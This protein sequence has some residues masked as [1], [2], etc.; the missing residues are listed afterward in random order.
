MGNLL[1]SVVAEP[2]YYVSSRFVLVLSLS[3]PF[4]SLLTLRDFSNN[5]N[6]F[7]SPRDQFLVKILRGDFVHLTTMYEQ[8]MID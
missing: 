2:D 7:I 6:F 3:L 1:D 8:L 4:Y 5:F